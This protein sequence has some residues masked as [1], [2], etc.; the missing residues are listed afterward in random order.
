MGDGRGPRVGDEGACIREYPSTQ[1]SPVNR[2]GV[3]MVAGWVLHSRRFRRDGG[4]GIEAGRSIEHDV[5]TAY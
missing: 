2:K 1:S 4:R 3:E 5:T